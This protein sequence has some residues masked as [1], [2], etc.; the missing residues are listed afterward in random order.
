MGDGKGDDGL[1]QEI[2][3]RVAERI[4]ALKSIL[5]GRDDMLSVAAHEIR[6]PLASLRLYL[7]ALIKAAERGALDP[8]ESGV[9]LR[10]AQRQ[11]DRLNILLNNLLDVARSPVRPLSVATE[12]VDL[13]VV[14]KSVCDRLRD[15]FA[16]QGRALDVVAPI[17]TL[18]GDWDRTRLEQVLTNLVS[19]AHKHAPGASARVEVV[20]REGERVAVTVSDSGPGIKLELR[21]RLFERGA[22]PPKSG[23]MGL[24]L[25]IV[26]QIVNAFGGTVRLD[27]G[28]PGTSITFELP[29]RA[30]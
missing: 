22:T 28:A 21:E 14:I 10:K 1:E 19:N 15:Q 4:G 23:G 16:H 27:S 12:P 3:R 25:W 2:N 18:T 9:R 8:V 20:V 7:D 17:G 6:T 29:R 24:G 13:I 5:D 11:C 30:A 26:S